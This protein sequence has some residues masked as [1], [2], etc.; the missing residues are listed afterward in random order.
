MEKVFIPVILGTNREGRNSEN[1]AKWLMEQLENYPEIETVLFDARDFDLPKSDY[2]Q[3]IKGEFFAWTQ[4]TERADGFI[5][6]VPEYN[7]GYPGILKS[8]LDMLFPEFH[9]KVAG[10]VGLSIGPWG[11]VRALENL[12]PVLREFKMMVSS[13]DLVF[14]RV[15]DVVSEDGKIQDDSYDKKLEKFLTDLVWWAKTL[16]EGR[17]TG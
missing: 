7:H 17:V 10:L 1:V 3:S 9:H 15:Q 4:A 2:G 14:P 16:R 5:L 11:G 6:I 12:V 13:P 8:M